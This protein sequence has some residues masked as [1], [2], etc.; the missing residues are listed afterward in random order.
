MLTAFVIDISEVL[1]IELNRHAIKTAV[2]IFSLLN[3]R[4]LLMIHIAISLVATLLY[5]YL[6]ASGFKL[7][8]DRQNPS[9]RAK[10]KK[11]S[12]IFITARLLNFITSFLIY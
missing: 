11:M 7:L 3:G 5:F 10:H 1:Y 6:I 4:T 2:S 8:K 9:Q 12:Y